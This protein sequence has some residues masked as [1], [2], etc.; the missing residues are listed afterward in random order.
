MPELL[1]HDRQDEILRGRVGRGGRRRV[2]E[3]GET[4]KPEY[5]RAWGWQTR[6]EIRDGPLQ[7]AKDPH[8][9]VALNNLI[10]TWRN[11]RVYE[12]TADEEDQAKVIQKFKK[13]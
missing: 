9:V 12:T 1:M 4:D 3:G 5:F 2:W 13:F 7:M 10:K 8:F 11:G 6:V